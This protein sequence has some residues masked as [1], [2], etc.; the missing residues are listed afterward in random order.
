MKEESKPNQSL[1]NPK[2]PT[3]KFSDVLINRHAKDATPIKIDSSIEKTRHLIK[4]NFPTLEQLESKDEFC[5]LLYDNRC[6]DKDVT[7]LLDKNKWE[8]CE[9]YERYIEHTLTA[10]PK[11]Y[12]LKSS[13]LEKIT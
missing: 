8:A 3:L 7:C 2:A 10:P 12:D 11:N 5:P 1:Y 9:T 6:K 4:T 13:V